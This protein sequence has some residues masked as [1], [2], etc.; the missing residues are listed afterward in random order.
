MTE[1]VSETIG[2][3]IEDHG[4]ITFEEFMERAL[5]GPGGF[6]ERHP[7]GVHGDFVTGPHVHPVFALLL[8]DAVREMHGLLGRPD[9]FEVV[10][11]GAG[12]GTL[13]RALLDALADFA[14]RYTATERSPGTREA[15]RS[16]AGIADAEELP[17]RTHVVIANELL[18][19][20]PFRV[21]RGHDEVRVGFRDGRFVGVLQPLDDELAPFA[22]ASPD[23]ERAVPTGALRFIERVA[24]RIGETPGYALLIDYGG[25]ASPAGEVHGYRAHRVVADVLEDPGGTD[26][27]AGVDFSLV[28][29]HATGQG[30]EAFPTVSQREALLALGFEN[31]ARAEL[32]VQRRALDEGR[33]LEAA[34]AWGGRSRATLLLD[35]AALGRLRWLLLAAPGLPRPGW[36]ERAL[37]DRNRPAPD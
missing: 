13:A 4:P 21:I 3:A 32:E 23:E 17:D 7:V 9:P 12:D 11:A 31:W 14:L 25:E 24:A 2:R 19:N 8:A 36:L 34:R 16:I 1:T 27:T 28:A 20:L 15:L 29:G 26:I 35:P 5:Y 30:L 6:Y 10:E 37:A 22:G 33:G 18:D